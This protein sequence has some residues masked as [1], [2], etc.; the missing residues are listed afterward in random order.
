[1]ILAC[2]FLVCMILVYQ[3]TLSSILYYLSTGS[4]SLKAFITFVYLFPLG[5]VLGLPLPMAIRL[6][7][8]FDMA[9]IIP[10]MLAVNG[11]SS[12]FGSSMT[13]VLAMTF[14]Y[15][16]AV[17]AAATCYGIVFIA[18]YLISTEVRKTSL[19]SQESSI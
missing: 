14:G 9:E 2:S 15:G 19:I 1:M 13:V 5:F 17:L 8:L 18:S 3:V 12:V 10:W 11:A 4:I 7:K 16:D 6:I